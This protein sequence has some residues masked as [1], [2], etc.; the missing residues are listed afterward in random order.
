MKKGVG[1]IDACPRLR[2][3]GAD[4]QLAGTSHI[5][6]SNGQAVLVMEKSSGETRRVVDVCLRLKTLV[7]EA[8]VFWTYLAER[9]N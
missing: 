4:W 8:T 7:S 3:V 6:Q 2:L 1:L 9:A 5:W